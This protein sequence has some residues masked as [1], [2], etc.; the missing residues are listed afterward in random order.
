MTN[1]YIRLQ[2][3]DINNGFTLPIAT[4]SQDEEGNLIDTTP[5]Q[6]RVICG[7]PRR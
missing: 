3:F 7:L 4:A 1:S 6:F 2:E 5:T